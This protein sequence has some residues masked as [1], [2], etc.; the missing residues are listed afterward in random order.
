MLLKQ[1]FAI[2]HSAGLI[3]RISRAREWVCQLYMLPHALRCLV[4]RLWTAQTMRILLTR[5]MRTYGLVRAC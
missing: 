5:A 1:H 3:V 2:M 4:A